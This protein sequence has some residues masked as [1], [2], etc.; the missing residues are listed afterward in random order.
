MEEHQLRGGEG[1]RETEGE[2]T[3]MHERE[4]GHET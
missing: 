3:H 4:E 2:G 1:T